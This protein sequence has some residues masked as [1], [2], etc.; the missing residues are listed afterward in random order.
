MSDFNYY[1]VIEPQHE[2]DFR[3]L[4][5]TYGVSLS[6]AQRCVRERINERGLIYKVNKKR[7][8]CLIQIRRCPNLPKNYTTKEAPE[9]G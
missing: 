5:L 1:V 4:I 3:P 2:Q 9:N 8:P 6:E 7:Y